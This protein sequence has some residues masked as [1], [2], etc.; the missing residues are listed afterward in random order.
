MS[1]T[2]YPDL[3]VD[4][5]ALINRI[6]ALQVDLRMLADWLARESQPV[7]SEAALWHLRSSS[8]ALQRLT[9]ARRH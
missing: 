1:L 7:L 2:V 5:D 8:D 6:Q 4:R 3:P 9:P